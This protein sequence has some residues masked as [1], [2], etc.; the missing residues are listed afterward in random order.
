MEKKL[1]FFFCLVL[2]HLMRKDLIFV[3]LFSFCFVP[4]LFR[5]WSKNYELMNNWRNW[6]HNRPEGE[7]RGSDWLQGH[8]LHT[9]ITF[10]IPFKCWPGSQPGS[11]PDSHNEKL[12]DIFTCEKTGLKSNLRFSHEWE[13]RFCYSSLIAISFPLF[14]WSYYCSWVMKYLQISSKKVV[15]EAC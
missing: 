7:S 10:D 1:I 11:Q 14:F 2:F 5:G 15:F 8:E 4:V 9:H 3:W 12:I 13:L 6:F